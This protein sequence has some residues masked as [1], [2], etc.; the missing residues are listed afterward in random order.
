MMIDA[1]WFA[2]REKNGRVYTALGHEPG[3]RDGEERT[4]RHAERV[5]MNT[6]GYHAADSWLHALADAP[7]PIACRVRLEVTER[8]EDG[9]L[10]GPRCMLVA[11]VDASHE[12][13]LF[14]ADC[15]E[16]AL[17]YEREAGRE[18]D[19]RSVAAIEAAR[20][21]V[22]GEIDAQALAAARSD[23]FKVPGVVGLF[24]TTASNR[25]WAVTTPNDTSLAVIAA[26][27][28]A[29]AVHAAGAV[30]ADVEAELAWQA[31]RLDTLMAAAMK[32]A[33]SSQS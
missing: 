7:G 24:H 26:G 1:Y 5:R 16:R 10:V 11:H 18:P 27:T 25:A 29:F 12:L 30:H 32:R 6:W 28:A 8:T 17:L 20:A 33:A 13:R 15:A 21:Y 4:V 2:E 14:A 23:A 9:R 3:W 31:E 22:R 19:P